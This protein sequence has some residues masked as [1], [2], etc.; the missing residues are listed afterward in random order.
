[1]QLGSPTIAGKPQLIGVTLNSYPNIV[2]YSFRGQ[3]LNGNTKPEIRIPGNNVGAKLF[4]LKSARFGCT[5]STGQGLGNAPTACTLKATF[6]R[7][8]NVVRSV[9][10]TFTFPPTDLRPDL[11]LFTFPTDIGYVDSV[12]F[13]TEVSNATP[14][15]TAAVL[16]DLGLVISK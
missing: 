11:L 7:S 1:M 10:L 6:S 5:T 13:G 14:I 15:L 12:V 3:V 4:V 2:T 16:D 9:L 8:G